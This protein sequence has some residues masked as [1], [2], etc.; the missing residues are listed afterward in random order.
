VNKEKKSSKLIA[1]V[2][3]ARDLHELHA[4]LERLLIHCGYDSPLPHVKETIKAVENGLDL[5][6]FCTRLIG[7]EPIEYILGSI[8]YLGLSLNV[9]ENVLIPRPETQVLIERAFTRYEHLVESGAKPE[10]ICMIDVGTGSGNIILSIDK[11]MP[12]DHS[13]TLVATDISQAAVRTALSNVLSNTTSQ[14]QLIL[15]DLFVDIPPEYLAFPHLIIV[16]NP[17]Y[18]SKS[19]YENLNQ[20][21]IEY[22]PM[23]ALTDGEDGYEIIR[24]LIEQCTQ[25]H[26]AV[27]NEV[28]LC[29]EAGNDLATMIENE[30]VQLP[31]ESTTFKDQ[32]EVERFIEASFIKG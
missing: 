2:H 1:K 15:S 28:Y 8:D 7:D 29:I 32:F 18:I 6:E 21:V 25:L 30:K 20:S 13:P 22:E 16:S 9:N 12:A 26:E 31:T 27:E 23:I 4:P 19:D 17:P 10:E 24:R 3:A 5:G 14:I 11:L